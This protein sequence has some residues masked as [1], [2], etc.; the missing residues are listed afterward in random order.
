MVP[1]RI[2]RRFAGLAAEGRAGF[3]P[4][5]T[6]GYPTLSDTRDLLAG[7]AELGADV[8]E[9]GIPFSDPMA[10]GPTIQ[11]SSR[12]ALE[13]GTTVDDVFDVLAELRRESHVPVVI[14]SYL[15]PVY[16]RGIETFAREAV[17]AGADGILPTD[18]PLGADPALEAQLLES[19]LDFVRLIAPT[20]SA[21]RV[22]EIAF[23]SQG[24]VYYIARAGVTGARAEL[25]GELA[26][27]A[28]AVRTV[29]PVPVAAGFGVSTPEHAR[30]V[31][32]ACDAVVV[33]SALVDRLDERG[34]A[35]AL[36]L[37]GEVR[38]AL[39]GVGRI[40]RSREVRGSRIGDRVR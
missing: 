33:G 6:A 2:A 40:P 38:A 10:D 30:A 21:D 15:N 13:G 16:A 14:F 34:V 28:G 3:I 22:R 39:D 27:E 31:G 5:V 7:L 12:G 19:P 20:T 17:D 36:A 23:A 37:A 18:L 26:A 1:G 25:R 29:S 32:S 9:L 24:F 8:I 4:Y 11:R 35:G